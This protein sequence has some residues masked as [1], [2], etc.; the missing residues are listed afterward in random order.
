MAEALG[1]A[2]S[3]LAV[4]ELSANIG[5]RC[6]K[7]YKAVKNARADIERVRVEVYSLQSVA[8]NA[9]KLLEG[10]QGAGLKASQQLAI[11]VRGAESR[12][13]QLEVELRPS[14]ARK[15]LSRM[16][17]RALKWPFKSKEVEGIVKDIEQCTRLFS[18]G[19]QL[20][21]A[22]TV[23]S[24]DEKLALDKLPTAPGAS[25]D[26]Q[27]EESSATCLP[28]TRVELLQKIRAWANDP[29]SQAVF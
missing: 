3:V 4:A 27:A 15:A 17:S 21:I 26:S 23:L 24:I 18:T 14:S 13:E 28:D 29:T 22:T 7:Y 12:L 10:P 6:V 8:N 5:S 2:S 16:H 1:I 19:L 9:L 20:D 25:Y 11:A